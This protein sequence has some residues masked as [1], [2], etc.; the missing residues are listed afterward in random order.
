MGKMKDM[1]VT[2]SQD[3]YMD[4]GYDEEDIYAGKA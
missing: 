1:Y 3:Y 2:D 4:C